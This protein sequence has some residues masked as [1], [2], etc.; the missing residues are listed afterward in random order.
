VLL[1]RLEADYA[2]LARLV[3]ELHVR[4]GHLGAPAEAT[5]RAEPQP[6]REDAAGDAYQ[7][8]LAAQPTDAPEAAAASNPED[9]AMPSGSPGAWLAPGEPETEAPA[10]QP[11]APADASSPTVPLPLAPVFLPRVETTTTV[12]GRVEVM[13]SPVAD[14]DRL[15]SLDSALARVEGVGAVTLADYAR[16]EVVFRIELEKPFTAAAFA[17]RLSETAGLPATVAEAS[18]SVLSLRVG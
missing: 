6:A 7:A 4:I 17:E 13:I 11:Q 16:E 9:E 2:L 5:G 10:P 12:F 8:R 1:E 14:F 3:Q 18:E 15:L